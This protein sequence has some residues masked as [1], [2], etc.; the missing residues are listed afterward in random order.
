MGK[1]EADGMT[2]DD[3]SGF[4]SAVSSTQECGAASAGGYLCDS[5]AAKTRTKPVSGRSRCRFC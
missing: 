1:D 3:S 2:D 4:D 5:P